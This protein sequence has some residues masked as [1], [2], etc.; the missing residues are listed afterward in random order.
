MRKE[1][2]YRWV[3]SVNGTEYHNT[4]M[5]VYDHKAEVFRKKLPID[6]DHIDTIRHM[7]IGYMSEP[8]TVLIMQSQDKSHIYR[9]DKI[10]TLQF[11][12]KGINR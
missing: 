7:T 12:Y 11:I 6:I 3:V 9:M 4:D 5:V 8:N 2:V 1:I 10:H